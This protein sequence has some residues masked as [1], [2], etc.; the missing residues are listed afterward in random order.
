MGIGSTYI[1]QDDLL[2]LAGL[3]I[4]MIME[5]T[6]IGSRSNDRLIRKALGTIP[7]KTRQSAQLLGHTP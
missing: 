2:G 3:A 5:Y 1:D 7:D 6:S 4:G